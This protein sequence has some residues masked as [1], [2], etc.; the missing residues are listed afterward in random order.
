MILVE[1]LSTF[2]LV[3]KLQIFETTVLNGVKVGICEFLHVTVNLYGI[4]YF[5]LKSKPTLL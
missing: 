1:I 5:Y 3:L 2:D 4:Q